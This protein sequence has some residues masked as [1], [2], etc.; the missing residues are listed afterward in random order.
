MNRDTWTDETLK[1]VVSSGYVL[2]QRG[3]ESMGGKNF[4]MLYN[5]CDPDALVSPSVIS[6]IFPALFFI[7]PRTGALVKAIKVVIIYNMIEY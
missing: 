5:I 1:E 7:D 4:M 2:W 6:S 3:S